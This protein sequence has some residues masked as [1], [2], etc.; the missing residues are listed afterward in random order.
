[1]ADGGDEGSSGDEQSSQA[2]ERHQEGSRRN[3]RSAR[4]ASAPGRG[5]DGGEASPDFPYINLLDYCSSVM[6]TVQKIA[7]IVLLVSKVCINAYTE[8]YSRGSALA[9]HSGREDSVDN[10]IDLLY[11][12][13][14]DNAPC[15]AQ[16]MALLEVMPRFIDYDAHTDILDALGCLLRVIPSDG[17]GDESG[18]QVELSDVVFKKKIEVQLQAVQSKF[19]ESLLDQLHTPT[20][21]W[22]RIKRVCLEHISVLREQET[23]LF[24]W[25]DKLKNGLVIVQPQAGSDDEDDQNGGS[26]QGNMY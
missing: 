21:N 3:Q 10:A 18:G 16:F 25:N 9:A 7:N 4:D 5:E 15:S 6:S 8:A 12:L 20:N 1:M 24:E 14:C 19:L 17:E 11:D 22:A 23:H 2:Q 13:M 26:D